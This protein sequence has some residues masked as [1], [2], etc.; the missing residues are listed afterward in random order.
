VK[1]V[2]IET[3]RHLYGGALQVV[4]LLRGLRHQYPDVESTL[5]C[6]PGSD[7]SQAARAYAHHIVEMPMKGDTD[8]GFVSRLGKQ[9]RHS[10]PDVLHLHSRRGA[11]LWGGL[12]GKLNHIPTL[13]TRRV[14]NPEPKPWVALKYQLYNHIVT[15]SHGI[16]EV[17]LNEGLAPERVTCI[18]SATDTQQYQPSSDRREALLKH[19]DLPAHAIVMAVIAQLIERKGHRYLFDALPAIIQ[20]HP[21]AHLL[22][23][24]K[25]ALAQELKNHA[26]RLSLQNNIHFA[27]FR[28]DLDKILPGLDLVIHP[29]LIEGLGV[30]LLQAAACGVPIIA[31]NAGGMPEVVKHH[32]NGLLVAPGNTTELQRAILSLLDQP[33]QRQT[34]AQHAR[35]WVLENFSIEKMTT[36]NYRMYQ[37]L[38]AK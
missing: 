5:I 32:H 36:E 29:A 14:D 6:V 22:V 24:G 15:I 20:Q 23:F 11:D 17:L 33:N 12:A 4:Y 26:T 27:G 34:L 37:R 8:I 35:A 19:F 21:H 10:K 1:I 28:T 38:L 16:R 25:G 31:S 2:H 9:L 3:G 30:S 18:H 13:L 7:I